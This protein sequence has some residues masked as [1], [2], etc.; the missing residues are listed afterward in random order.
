MLSITCLYS[1]QFSSIVLQSDLCIEID[2]LSSCS[3]F[4]FQYYLVLVP[5]RHP[6]C[7]TWEAK[8][9][10]IKKI[11]GLIVVNSS[12]L[13]RKIGQSIRCNTDF[14]SLFFKNVINTFSNFIFDDPSLSK[15]STYSFPT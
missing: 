2:G 15:L 6:V 1:S 14:P 8:R 3:L 4:Y 5:R 7:R 11:V 13:R 9:S 10:Q 12:T